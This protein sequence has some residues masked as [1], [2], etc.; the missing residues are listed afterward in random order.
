MPR[1]TKTNLISPAALN[2][3]RREF[4]HNND[5]RREFVF[6]LVV[7]F[8]LGGLLMIFWQFNVRLNNAA[9]AMS[10]LQQATAQNSQTV[11]DIVNF[12][13][14]ATGQNGGTSTP[15]AQ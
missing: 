1:L 5:M 9:V 6:P 11:G 12:I 7:G 13:N 10:Q 8:I 15:A 3:Y 4:N 2:S 14:N